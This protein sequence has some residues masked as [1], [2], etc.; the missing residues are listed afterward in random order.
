MVYNPY[1]YQPHMYQHAMPQFLPP[2]IQHQPMQQP[3]QNESSCLIVR[4]AAAH[5]EAAYDV[6]SENDDCSDSDTS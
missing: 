5:D 4:V 6:D 1:A 3:M 2:P